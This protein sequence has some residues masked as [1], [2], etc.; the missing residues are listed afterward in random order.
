MVIVNNSLYLIKPSSTSRHYA[1]LNLYLCILCILYLDLFG[2]NSLPP[3]VYKCSNIIIGPITSV[4]GAVN[5]T[6]INI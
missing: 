6:Y 3:V 1:M 2:N 5:F 4:V